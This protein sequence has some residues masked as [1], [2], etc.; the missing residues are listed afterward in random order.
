MRG[1]TSLQWAGQAW[2]AQR[3]HSHAAPVSAVQAAAMAEGKHNPNGYTYALTDQAVPETIKIW[4][5]GRLVLKSAV[6]IGI[7]ASPTADGAF[8]V[9]LRYYFQIMQGTNPDGSQYAGPV[10]YVSY[11]N[12]GDAVHYFSRA[13]TGTTRAWA[14]WSCPGTPRRRPIRT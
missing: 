11:F 14:A 13:A 12:G 3:D 2:Q 1:L 8:P 5:N 4:H 6:S 9:Y 7:P 10:Y